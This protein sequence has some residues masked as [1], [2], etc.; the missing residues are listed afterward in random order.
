MYK[1][2]IVALFI[3][4]R[5]KRSFVFNMEELNILWS[6]HIIEYHAAIKKSGS[7]MF[8]LTQKVI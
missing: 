4:V 6:D 7:K 5:L 3:I 8:L 2:L 1:T